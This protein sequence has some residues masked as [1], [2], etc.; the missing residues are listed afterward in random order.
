MKTDKNG[1]PKLVALFS[2]LEW[3]PKVH[4]WS[5]AISRLTAEQWRQI[6]AEATICGNML[7]QDEASGDDIPDVDPQANLE[8]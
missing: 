6:T 2:D 4:R 3:G 7:P 5:Q 1:K 8:L